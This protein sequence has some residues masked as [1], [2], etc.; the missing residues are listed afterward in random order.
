[1]NNTKTVHII[2]SKQATTRNLT[3]FLFT[4]VISISDEMEGR[5]ASWYCY[6]DGF[7]LVKIE[8][9]TNTTT[10]RRGLLHI[11]VL[12]GLAFMSAV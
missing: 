10:F 1:M 8:I 12:E 5:V 9:D 4:E 6:Y 7:Y 2:Q 3:H 11:L